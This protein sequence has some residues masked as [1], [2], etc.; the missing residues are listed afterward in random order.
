MALPKVAEHSKTLNTQLLPHLELANEPNSQFKKERKE[1]RKELFTKDDPLLGD[2][3]DEDIV[4]QLR[5]KIASLEEQI[6]S[7]EQR[8]EVRK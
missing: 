4:L 7:L 2:E 5:S 3:Y 6:A 8:P 1:L